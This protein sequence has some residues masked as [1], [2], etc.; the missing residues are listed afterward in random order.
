M[1]SSRAGWGFLILVLAVHV[2][3]SR[4]ETSAQEILPLVKLRGYGGV[5]GKWQSVKDG[6]VLQ[7]QCDSADKAKLLQAKYI[8]DLQ[9]LP[10]V[11][12]LQIQGAEGAIP[13]FAMGTNAF[14]AARDGRQVFVLTADSP[15]A[16]SALERSSLPHGNLVFQPEMAVPM[17]LDRW[18]KYGLRFYYAPFSTPDGQSLNTYDKNTDFAW[19]EK[20][21]TGL[22][23]WDP[24]Y[25]FNVAQGVT[26]RSDMRWA[27]DAAQAHHLPL[28]INLS[29]L[30]TLW[31]ANW[32][33]NDMAQMAP[34]F[35]GSYYNGPMG[36]GDGSRFIS[37]NSTVAEDMEL[38]A[39]QQDV[40]VFKSY[41]NVTSWLEP[42]G[43]IGH[44]DTDFLM[45]YGPLAD[46]TFREWL[47]K[48][49]SSVGT[50]SQRWTGKPDTFKSWTDI[51]V[52]EM[53]S[54]CGWS[55]DALDLT[56]KWK[57]NYPPISNQGDQPINYP[58][59][60]FAATFDDSSWPEITAPGDANAM[61]LPKTP[62]IFRRTFTVDG[63]WLKA[64]P[65]TWLY[66]FDINETSGKEIIATLNSKEVGRSKVQYNHSGWFE[67]TG[68]LKEGSN[69]LAL[70][71]PQG[72]LA[73]RVY[74]SGTEPH[75]YPYLGTQMN[76]RWADFTDWAAWSRVQKVQRGLEMIRQVDPDRGIIMMTPGPFAGGEQELA[77][78]YGGDFH[79]TG[80][81][82]GWWNTCYPQMMN[83]VGM[84]VSVETGGPDANVDALAQ[85]LGRY[86]TEGIQGVDYFINIGSIF[87]H[88]DMKAK[89]EENLKLWKLIGKYHL[90]PPRYAMF[91]SGRDQTLATF[92]FNFPDRN[93]LMP[94]GFVPWGWFDARYPGT[95]GISEDEFFN[96]SVNK[97]KVIF[98]TN[99][100]IMDQDMINAIAVY[101]KQG[102]IFCTY[103]QTGRHS[104]TEPNSWPIS[105]LTGYSVTGI[106]PFP[107]DD[108]KQHNREIAPAPNQTI[109][110]AETW[111]P[112]LSYGS[113][114]LSLKKVAPEC[115]DLLVWKDG[116]IA[117]GMRPLGKGY[118]FDLGV[119]YDGVGWGDRT[120]TNQLFDAILD[121]AKIPRD[122][123]QLQNSA[124]P[125]STDVVDQNQFYY[126][127]F[128]SN[129]GLY[130][131]FSFYNAYKRPVTADVVFP[132]EAAALTT[133]IRVKT[134]EMRPLTKNAAGQPVLKLQ[135]DGGE[136][137]SFLVP[138]A[139][140]TLASRDWFALQREWWKGTVTPPAKQL[141]TYAAIHRNTLPLDDGWLCKAL[142]DQE[143][144]E[145]LAAPNVDDS[146]WEKQSIVVRLVPL[147]DPQKPT[148]YLYRK[149]FTVP[150]SWKKGSVALYMTPTEGDAFPNLAKIYC[151]GRMVEKPVPVVIN[152]SFG[153]VLKP[154]SS[155]LLA[156]EIQNKS[157]LLGC[158]GSSWLYYRPDPIE[159]MDLA[160][161]WEC[162]DDGLRFDRKATLPGPWDAKVARRV[163]HI[164]A[165]H[166]KQTVLLH[167]EYQGP[168]TGIVFNGRW[169]SQSHVANCPAFDLNLTPWI[170]FGA[171]N[172]LEVLTYQKHEGSIQKLSLDFYDP[173]A[174][175]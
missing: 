52:P 23:V 63:A 175:P 126:R 27:A 7:I 117:A 131:V 11:V 171:D 32:F 104:S 123:I 58:T 124:F 39:I 62:A 35:L 139:N 129:N 78:K 98:D 84:P 68:A 147:P 133:A 30:N 5:S 13:G 25:E 47:Q 127:H 59:D 165:T 163:I 22:Q 105:Q 85:T 106:D 6:S 1:H 20:N 66:E 120:G 24:L 19:S 93:L 145:T 154:G 137:Q 61:F 18:D 148:T 155:H 114:G 16:L 60:T 157:S 142:T 144:G 79:D 158:M 77:K 95:A 146:G 76:A 40:R 12:P 149:H 15:E 57:V 70:A 45:E 162:S 121:F 2:G 88:P 41:D 169:I 17:Y 151:D 54:F 159:K 172:D 71:L 160:G 73:Y 34:E 134:G 9:V 113:A 10:G 136:S 36:V 115:K 174:R 74:I 83:G 138:H 135:L 33:P 167:C 152:E 81:M 44:G 112:E 132:A 111:K 99:S 168:F 170:K 150:A 101:V 173:S 87:W 14:L 116:S 4:A 119:K 91:Y 51:H 65:R 38:A 118:I 48:K 55:S 140:V 122:P 37:W 108:T 153:G 31:L 75:T 86:S 102:G 97:Y 143:K 89:F 72:F 56:G 130:D 28:G 103:L 80:G 125:G 49:Y 3:I 29:T 161:E 46:K 42:H 69:V 166:A 92:P 141:P 109:Y 156:V 64:H 96:G 43:E 107:P 21:Q 90:P 100:S 128:L 164:P 82:Q 94:M 8:S 110:T 26:S 53:A 50:V 67:V